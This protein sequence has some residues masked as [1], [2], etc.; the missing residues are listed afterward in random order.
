MDSRLFPI[1]CCYKQCYKQWIT[2]H[3][4]HLTLMQ[5]YLQDTF[6]EAE[7][8]GPR[9]KAKVVLMMLPNCP[10]QGNEVGPINFHSHQQNMIVSIFPQPHKQWIFWIISSRIGKKWFTC[11]VLSCI[12]IIMNEDVHIFIYLA[13]HIPFYVILY[14]LCH[15]SFSLLVLLFLIFWLWIL[16]LHYLIAEYS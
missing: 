4:Y 2:R 7:L 15:F 1:F 5:V 11:T 10:P 13:I 8:L 12:Y 9:I 14:I 6:P 3:T 16:L